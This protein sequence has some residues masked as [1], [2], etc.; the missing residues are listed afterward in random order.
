MS[1]YQSG[2]TGA[3]IDAAIGGAVPDDA[4]YYAG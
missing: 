1:N 2:Y 4:F 3:Q